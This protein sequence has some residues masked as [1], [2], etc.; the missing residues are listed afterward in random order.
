MASG[1]EVLASGALALYHHVKGEWKPVKGDAS[2]KSNASLLKS[3]KGAFSVK[4][5]FNATS[6]VRKEEV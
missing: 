3:T 2:S 1:E 6:E 5:T 4:V